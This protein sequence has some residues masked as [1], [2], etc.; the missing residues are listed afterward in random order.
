MSFMPFSSINIVEYF[1]LTANCFSL[2]INLKKNLPLDD[3][4]FKNN[5]Q[6]SHQLSSKQGINLFRVLQETINNALKHAKATEI[7]IVLDENQNQLL[8]K[9]QDN[10]NGFDYEEKK[11]KSY[12]LSN[13]K[14]RIEELNG[15]FVLI[16]NE[17]GTTINITIPIV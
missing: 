2:R 17:T 16:S 5:I 14:N 4:D 9:I 7:N 1:R 8:M 10:G 11:K 6:N 12:G 3:F 15:N 13:I